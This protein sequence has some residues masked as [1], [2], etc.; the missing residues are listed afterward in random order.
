MR[1]DPSEAGFEGLAVS[2]CGHARY[3]RERLK[4]LLRGRRFPLA[5][6]ARGERLPLARRELDLAQADALRRH[7]DALVLADELERLL[8]REW[9]RR[10]QPHQLVGGRRAHVGQLLLL[11]GVHVEVVLARVLADDHPFVE[12]G[13][14]RDE[15]R[16]ALLQ[17]GDREGG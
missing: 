9:A 10:D 3:C 2:W 17:A 4:A 1:E 14:R 12:V 7:L 11:R 5:L 13:P 16:A 15:E 8:E 6:A